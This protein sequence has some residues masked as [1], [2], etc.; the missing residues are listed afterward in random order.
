[1]LR[2]HGNEKNGSVARFRGTLLLAAAAAAAAAVVLLLS[3]P[4]P[5]AASGAV[6]V[7]KTVCTIIY[8]Q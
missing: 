8:I 7:Q 4:P 5:A 2:E 1:M 3:L 6:F